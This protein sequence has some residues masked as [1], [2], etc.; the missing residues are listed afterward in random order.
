MTSREA[1]LKTLRTG[2]IFNVEDAAGPVRV[3]LTISVTETAIV[4]R[5][6][7]TQEIIEFDRRKGV[8]IHFWHSGKYEYV[9][10]SLAP[11]PR[12]IHEIMLSLDRRY[13]ESEYKL[14]ENPEWEPSP[15]ESALTKE[16]IRGLLF[17]ADFYRANLLPG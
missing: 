6:V 8:A 1:A 5:S 9:I 10:N 12:D 15:G 2:D 17:V 14:A 4:A 16:Q 3:C 7:T 11:L 13:R